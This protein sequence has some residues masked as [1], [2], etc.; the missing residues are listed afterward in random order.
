ME[1]ETGYDYNQEGSLI[2]AEA[3]ERSKKRRE[4]VQ[5][6]IRL[7]SPIEPLSLICAQYIVFTFDNRPRDRSFT[8]KLRLPKN[9]VRKNLARRK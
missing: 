5:G 4:S 1:A 2:T 8:T 9:F 6:I 7:K 3:L